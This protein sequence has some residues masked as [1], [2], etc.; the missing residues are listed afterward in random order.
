MPKPLTAENA[1]PTTEG[2][3]RD[4]YAL[5]IISPAYAAS[6][7]E[8][9]AILLYLYQSL[10]FKAEGYGGYAETIE[11]IAI[12]EMFHL[13]L[14]GETIVALGA[15]PVF[16]A[17]PPAMF[18]FYSTKFVTYS[19]TLVC[20]AEDGVRAEREAIRM[21]ERMLRWLRNEKVCEIISR[22]LEDERLHLAAFEEILC[23]LKAGGARG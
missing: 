17:C 19:R 20:M 9:N 8:L 7:G 5:R 22:I 3:S 1:Y 2:I 15:A 21:Y 18:N 16:T 4:A 6:A 11:A 10:C 13:K 14:L 12:A 23:G